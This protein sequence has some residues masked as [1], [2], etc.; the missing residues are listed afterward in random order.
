M[1]VSLGTRAAR[2]VTVASALIASFPVATL[3]AQSSPLPTRWILTYA[4]GPKRPKYTV[5]DYVH[6]I[7]VVDTQGVP[8]G[9][10]GT[11]VLYLE[12]WASSGRAFATWAEHP[13]ANGSDW[14]TYLDT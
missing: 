12:V 13:W 3:A 1:G 11:G 10:L 9:W 8:L 4:G 14:Q 7:S 2:V 6:M 5:D